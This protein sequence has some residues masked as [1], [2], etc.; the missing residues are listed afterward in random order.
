MCDGASTLS[1]VGHGT[2]FQGQVGMVS[3]KVS[4][5]IRL[6]SLSTV[7][8]QWLVFRTPVLVHSQLEY[9]NSSW[10]I[11]RIIDHIIGHI[12][13]NWSYEMDHVGGRYQVL[14]RIAGGRVH[15]ESS[16]TGEECRVNS[17]KSL[18]H[19]ELIITFYQNLCILMTYLLSGTTI[20]R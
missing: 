13:G 10:F 19:N 7:R 18:I 3:S 16:E 6:I 9:L 2:N 20:P 4:P 5:M 8:Y 14:N 11:D 1:Y 15:E 17:P 12:I